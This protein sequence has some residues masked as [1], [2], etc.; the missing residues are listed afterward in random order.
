MLPYT[1]H[2]PS[3]GLDQ[4]APYLV[5]LVGAISCLVADAASTKEGSRR[6]LPW[7][8]MATLVAAFAAFYLPILPRDGKP[9]LE[10]VLVHTEFGNLGALTII[11]ASLGMAVMGRASVETRN[12]ATGEF[13]SLVLFATFGAVL[14]ALSNELLTAFISLEIM[15]L[16]LYVLA[17]IDRRSPR[18]AEAA[19]KYFILGA[20]AAAFFVMGTAFLYGAT[21]TTQLDRMREVFSL[22]GIPLPD[23][24]LAPL[25]GVYVY[26]GF[27]LLL[28]SLAFKLSLAPFHMWA[29][30][31]YEGAPTPSAMLIAT[32]SKVGAFALLFHLLASMAGWRPFFVSAGFLLAF[33]ALASMLWG[34][35]AAI[36][37]RNIKRMLAY[38]SI[39][40]GGYLMVG[41]TAMMATTHG[42]SDFDQSMLQGSVRQSILLYLFGYTIM[43]ALAFGLA[44]FLGKEGEGDMA[45]YRGLWKRNPVVAAGMAIAMFSLLGMPGTVGFM[46]KFFIFRHAIEAGLYWLASVGILASVISA[47]YY[48]RLVVNMFMVEE[49][50][51]APV[52]SVEGPGAAA[53]STRSVMLI[54]SAV[55]VILM[56]LLPMSYLALSQF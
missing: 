20:F 18:S 39:A 37:Q 44:H 53:A 29:P 2:I 46:G 16:S 50:E 34:N 28:V 51:G 7:I 36:Q 55:L 40:H 19:M 24:T 42:A 12:L 5:L 32:A 3:I 33:L 30:D 35:L 41:Y 48:L 6:L 15:S 4:M 27:A 49:E 38:S 21:A 45:S 26:V 47:F 22:G 54:V 14:L 11:F 8:T 9:F 1:P 17:G 52:A 13:Y 31:V 43:N 56:G 23:G 25:N 10:G